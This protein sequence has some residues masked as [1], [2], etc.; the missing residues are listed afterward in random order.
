MRKSFL[1]VGLA[2][3]TGCVAPILPMV[4]TKTT[5]YENG[6]I[7]SMTE[8]AGNR[9]H[10]THK[11][12]YPDGTLEVEAQYR[13]GALQ[14][15]RKIYRKDGSLESATNYEQNVADGIQEVYYPTGELWTKNTYDK[16]KLIKTE[17]FD[18]QGNP[19][20]SKEHP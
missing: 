8:Y 4:E 9:P 16:G 18:K 12:Y 7:K 19:I 20:E 17:T 3:L 10:G 6:T 13:M 1:V 14:G 11:Q 2:L 5:H 15:I